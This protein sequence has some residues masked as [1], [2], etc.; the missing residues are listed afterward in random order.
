VDNNSLTQNHYSKNLKKMK[1]G[2]LFNSYLRQLE[3]ENYS[4]FTPMYSGSPAE[5]MMYA[6]ATAAPTVM[7]S[8]VQEVAASDPYVLTITNSNTSTSLTAVI[9][10]AYANTNSAVTNW[11]SDV[12]ITITPSSGATYYALLAQSMSNP[13]MIYSWRLDADTIAQ[14]SQTLYVNYTNAGNGK[15]ARI[16]IN[17]NVRRNLYY[18]SDKG[19]EF[20]YPIKVDGNTYFTITILASSS[21]TLTMFPQAVADQTQALGGNV[22]RLTKEYQIP[23]MSV[24]PMV[25]DVNQ[26]T[27]SNVP[28]RI[29]GTRYAPPVNWQTMSQK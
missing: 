27:I 8:C 17:M 22:A 1:K 26:Q 6:D 18:N 5:Q 25:T 9:F 15:L 19:L 21:L 20:V 13:F 14:L 11:G 7:E 4:N 2:N 23:Q 3:S 12:G 29:V 28:S 10:G 24:M 16:P